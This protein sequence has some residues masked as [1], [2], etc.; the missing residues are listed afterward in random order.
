MKYIHKLL[1][2][3]ILL[4]LFS[5]AQSNFKPGYIVTLKG[6][7]LKGFINQK[8]WIYNPEDVT[9]KSDNNSTTQLFTPSSITAFGVTGSEYYKSYNGKISIDKS[10]DNELGAVLK[11]IDTTT[12]V[13][14]TFLMILYSGKNLSLLRYK[15]Q[16]KTRYFIAE[17]NNNIQELAYHVYID[18]SNGS[19]KI[20]YYTKYKQQLQL[21]R[22]AYQPG[23]ISLINDIQNTNYEQQSLIKIISKL[24]GGTNTLN[25]NSGSKSHVRFFAGVGAGLITTEVKNFININSSSSHTSPMINIGFDLAFNKNQG[26]FLFRTELTYTN[27]TVNTNVLVNATAVYASRQVLS[28]NHHLINLTPHLIYNICNDANFKFY[29]GAGPTLINSVYTNKRSYNEYPNSTQNPTQQYFPGLPPIKVNF[30]GKA[31]IMLKNK[32]DINF[33]YQPATQ[34]N[35][36][37]D[38]VVLTSYRLGINY[39]FGH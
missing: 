21:L 14:S 6:D 24:D 7:T 28:F 29:L 11:M 20:A 25:L 38:R 9:F 36:I 10:N 4:P 17:K 19:N 26:K 5:S 30:I 33:A 16:I 13:K 18:D 27:T 39:Y 23:S 31:G 2:A 3:F 37:A 22:T 15:D 34:T 12:V 8:E 32:F 1:A 35:G